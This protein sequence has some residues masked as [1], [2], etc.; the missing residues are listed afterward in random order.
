[1][2]HFGSWHYNASTS[3]MAAGD[4]RYIQFDE[5]ELEEIRRLEA[6]VKAAKKRLKKAKR[7]LAEKIVDEIF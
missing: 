3:G 4:E 2:K 7:K 6:E 1:M 5:D